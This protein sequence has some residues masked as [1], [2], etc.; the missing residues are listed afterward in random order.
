[1]TQHH[2]SQGNHG[3]GA[4]LHLYWRAYGG[5]RGFTR[6]PFLWV[7][8]VL[9]VVTAHFWVVEKWWEQVLSILPGLLGFTLGGFA[10]FLGFGDDKFKSII[11]G[12]KAG[13][14]TP[15]PYLQVCATFLHFVLI[16]TCGIVVALLA[17]ATDFPLTGPLVELG[18][19]LGSVKWIAGLFGYWLFL[20]G[21][22]LAV[23]AALAVFRVAYWFDTFKQLT[24]ENDDKQ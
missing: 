9:V 12:A 13:D 4:L 5:V 18:R 2:D 3:L 14:P 7:S 8:L 17:Q 19:F 20:Y 16:Q 10:I 6:S 11:S 22:C 24:E 23:A 21:L 15:S 1:M